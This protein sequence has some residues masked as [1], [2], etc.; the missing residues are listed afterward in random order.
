MALNFLIGVL[1]VHVFAEKFFERWVTEIL[2][3]FWYDFC[4]ISKT[5]HGE[6][7]SAWALFTLPASL[8][9][10]GAIAFV[11]SHLLFDTLFADK[12]TLRWLQLFDNIL[13][14][15]ALFDS[16][17][18]NRRMSRWKGLDFFICLIVHVELAGEVSE[19]E[20]WYL[21][22]LLSNGLSGLRPSGNKLLERRVIIISY[23]RNGV[24]GDALTSHSGRPLLE[25]VDWLAN[26]DAIWDALFELLSSL[27]HISGDCKFEH[28]EVFNA[29]SFLEVTLRVDRNQFVLLV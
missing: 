8:V 10:F 2:N 20:D 14:L 21:W 22:H 3:F 19:I 6:N 12:L 7:A 28:A 11:A 1:E 29:K 4:N 16:F 27:G 5:F 25:A 18:W 26:W 15:R 17:F 24:T 23:D 13:G 9:D